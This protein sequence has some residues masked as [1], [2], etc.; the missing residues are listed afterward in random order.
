MSGPSALSHRFDHKGVLVIGLV[1]AVMRIGAV[2]GDFGLHRPEAQRLRAFRPSRKRIP[3][4]LPGFPG[5]LQRRVGDH[6]LAGAR[7]PA[8]RR[9]ACLRLCRECPRAPFRSRRSRGSPPL[10]VRSWRCRYRGA[11][12]ERRLTSGSAPISISR[13][14]S[15]IVW[16]PGAS[17][18]ARA[19]HG[20][21]SDSPS[22][23]IPSIGSH[24]DDEAVLRRG[25]AA[26]AHI[27]GEQHVA[28]DLGD[29][30]G[31]PRRQ[32]FGDMSATAY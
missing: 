9:S 3:I 5:R 16:V 23:S 4:F 32:G 26:G 8:T 30:H 18:Q 7:R 6:G 15:P 25:G 1:H 14:P 28:L 10:A 29:F 31:V 24:D 2:H 20:L 19:I 12:R 27:G 21:T 17:T 11:P 13:I 22:P